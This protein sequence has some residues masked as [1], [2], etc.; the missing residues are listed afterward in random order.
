MEVLLLLVFVS[1]ALAL[2]GVGF[3][4]WSVRE[5]TF[6]QA[7]RLALM[8]LRDDA[9]SA[10]PRGARAPLAHPAPSPTDTT[11][12]VPETTGKSER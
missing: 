7:D 2:A 10:R 12:E 5:R 6:D 8:P 11:V 3:F 9:G 1:A 4:V